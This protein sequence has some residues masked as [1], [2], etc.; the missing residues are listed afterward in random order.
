M[1]KGAMELIN[2]SW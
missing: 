1:R 2:N